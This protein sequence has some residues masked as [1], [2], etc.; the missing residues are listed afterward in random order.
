MCESVDSDPQNGR[1]YGEEHGVHIVCWC[2]LAELQHHVQEME[3]LANGSC[4]GKSH[5]DSVKF[6]WRVEVD[7]PQVANQLAMMIRLSLI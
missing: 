6:L 3:E 5:D 7:T 1:H 4:G 2:M